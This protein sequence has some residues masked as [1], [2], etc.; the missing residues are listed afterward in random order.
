[1]LNRIA[2]H[3]EQAQ[4]GHIAPARAGAAVA[5]RGLN[6][7]YGPVVA[8]RD[9][10]LDIEAGEFVALLGASGS[11]KSTILMMIAG[12]ETASAGEILL[13]QRSITAL[14]PRGVM[15]AFEKPF[16][17]QELGISFGRGC[18]WGMHLLDAILFLAGVNK[19]REIRGWS[20]VD[21]PYGDFPPR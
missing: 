17:D 5:L 19:A 10:S 21:D 7:S 12:F 4:S 3:W 20:K 11:G 15:V 13:D 2:D 18:C 8:V 9:V 14:P 1:M 6:K 16:E